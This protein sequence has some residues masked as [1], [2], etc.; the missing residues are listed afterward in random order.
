MSKHLKEGGIKGNKESM[1][2]GEGGV[3]RNRYDGHCMKQWVKI[4]KVT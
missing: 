3:H 1:K 2:V 4:P